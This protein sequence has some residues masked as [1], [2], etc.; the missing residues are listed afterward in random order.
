MSEG[1]IIFAS[2]VNDVDTTFYSDPRDEYIRYAFL[3]TREL[4]ARI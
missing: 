4:S 2:E 1:S 3:S